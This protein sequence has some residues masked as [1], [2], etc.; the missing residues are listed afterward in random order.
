MKVVDKLLLDI[1]TQWSNIIT[2]LLLQIRHLYS[3]SSLFGRGKD[4]KHIY[5]CINFLFQIRRNCV[6]MCGFFH[7]SVRQTSIRYLSEMKRHNYVT[8]TSYLA[9]ILTF[10]SLL[11]GKRDEIL[12]LKTRYEMGLGKLEYASSQ[13]NW[14]N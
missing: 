3:H 13:V 2:S 10:K 1:W 4:K 14:W 7:E 5:I 8:P 11:T 6:K 12:N 9:L